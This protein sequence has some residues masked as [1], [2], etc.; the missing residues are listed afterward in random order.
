MLDVLVFD[1]VEM[2]FM[3][4]TLFQKCIEFKII[5]QLFHIY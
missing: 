1:Y 2:A 4:F 3:Y 5:L